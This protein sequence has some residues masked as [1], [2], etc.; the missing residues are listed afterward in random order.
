LTNGEPTGV[1]KASTASSPQTTDSTTPAS[2]TMLLP[3]IDPAKLP[4]EVDQTLTIFG[5]FLIA[6]L[7]SF[8]KI[9]E[10]LTPPRSGDWVAEKLRKVRS[11]IAEQ[12]L[13]A[14]DLPPRLRELAEQH[15][16]NGDR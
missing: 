16:T 2:V 12:A 5:P 8:R 9:G 7:W 14:P 13:E 1:A 4:P 15:R 11:A 6:G 10:Q 3:W